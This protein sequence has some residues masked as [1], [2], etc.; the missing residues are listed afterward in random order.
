MTNNI[1]TNKAVAFDKLALP[2]HS[3]IHRKPTAEHPSGQDVQAVR[4]FLLALQQKICTQIGAHEPNAQFMIDPW[5][6]DSTDGGGGGIAMVLEGGSVIEKAGVMLSHIGVANL[7]AS[8]SA[9]HPALHGKQAEA[10]GVSVVIHPKNPHIP[11]SHAN[12]RLFV[13]HGASDD[14]VVWWFGGGFDLT[15]FYPYQEDCVHWHSVCAD[16]CAPFGTYQ[17]HK[18]WCDRYFY[19]P[20]RDETRGVGGLFFDDLNAQ[21]GFDFAKAFAYI[22]AVGEGYL[23]ALL[24][25]IQK[26]KDTPFDKRAREFLAHRRGRYV[27][28]NLVLDR[29]TLFGLQSRGRTKSILVSMPPLASWR[30]DEQ[31]FADEY[32]HLM[33]FLRPQDWL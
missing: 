6:R 15:P 3:V 19:L 4:D 17:A 32:A 1:M 28:Y 10:M 29:G 30:Y 12:V 22:Q 14:D 21:S 24:P 13:A 27:E 7:P 11:T 33:P 8:A 18:Q 5:E 20:H 31:E 9:K 25:I 26:R 23:Q 2:P 16:I